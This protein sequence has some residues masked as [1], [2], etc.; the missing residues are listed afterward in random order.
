MITITT[1]TPHDNILII[2]SI[3]NDTDINSVVLVEKGTVSLYTGLEIILLIM[4]LV[5][6]ITVFNDIKL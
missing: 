4:L 6:C 1:M 5:N 2:S 3:T